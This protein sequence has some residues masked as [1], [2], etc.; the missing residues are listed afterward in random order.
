MDQKRGQPKSQP[1]KYPIIHK[2]NHSI[3]PHLKTHEMDTILHSHSPYTLYAPQGQDMHPSPTGGGPHSNLG[4]RPIH[5]GAE[6]GRQHRADRPA[7]QLQRTTPTH[8][9]RSSAHPQPTT[10]QTLPATPAN[11][12]TTVTRSHSP[13]IMAPGKSERQPCPRHPPRP[14]QADMLICNIHRLLL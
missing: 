6:R 1:D 7:P 12:P 4:G 14:K 9:Q 8:L 5:S 13:G 2:H 10:R 11:G 3:P